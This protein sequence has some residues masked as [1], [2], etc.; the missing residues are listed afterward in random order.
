VVI[1]IAGNKADQQEGKFNNSQVLEYCAAKGVEH[2]EVSAKTGDGV[3]L[4]FQ[5]L[6]EKLT[7]V[8][9]K[10]E[11][12]ETPQSDVVSKVMQKKNEF[13]LKSGAV[14]KTPAKKACC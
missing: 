1:A 14:E 3:D 9:P 11:K 6:A 8:H 2:L 5:N 4:V 12:K 7:K 10:A 13:K